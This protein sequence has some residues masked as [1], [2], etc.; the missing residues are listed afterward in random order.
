MIIESRNNTLK[1]TGKL[2]LIVTLWLCA[3][4]TVSMSSSFI[5]L[6]YSTISDL[7][8]GTYSYIRMNKTDT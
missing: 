5:L 7:M 2:R 8:V 4:S 3:I 1:N 6:L